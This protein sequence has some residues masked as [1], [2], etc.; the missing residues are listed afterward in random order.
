MPVADRTTIRATVDQLMTMLRANLVADPP[1]AT[2]PFRRAEVGAAEFQEFPR[3]F[4]T[5]N[6]T[7]AKPIGITDNDKVMEVST[8]FHIATDVT[9]ADPQGALLDALGAVEDYLDSVIDTGILE[10][11]EGVDDRSWTLEFPK[12]TS[13]AGVGVAK[14][15]IAFVVKVKRG[16][17]RVPAP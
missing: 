3:P 7:K 16:N 2:K 4:L 1:T 17:N 10:G 11:A 9:A 13:G 5:V 14:V 15:T 6:P 12:E 8:E